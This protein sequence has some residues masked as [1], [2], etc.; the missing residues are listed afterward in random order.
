MM[1]L[2]TTMLIGAAAKWLIYTAL[3]WI[4]IKVQKL[5]YSVLGL[6]ASSA[7][8]TLFD[9][10]PVVGPFIS[11]VVLVLCLWKCTKADIFPDV[12]FTVTIAGALMFCTN[13]WLLGAMIGNL[14]PDPLKAEARMDVQMQQNADAVSGSDEIP[15]PPKPEKPAKPAPAKPPPA[16]FKLKGVSLRSSKPMALIA[17]GKGIYTITAGES[18]PVSSPHGRLKVFCDEITAS[19]VTITIDDGEKVKLSLQ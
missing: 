17:A 5:N 11:Y 9:F 16:G 15:S 6:L 13:L 14:R 19:S 8:A 12:I 10:I 7:A 1:A 3:L 2:I 4:M 18:T